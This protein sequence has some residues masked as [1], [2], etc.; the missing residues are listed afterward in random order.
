MKS[1]I[2]SIKLQKKIWFLQNHPFEENQEEEEENT[3]PL[4]PFHRKFTKIK[5]DGPEYSYNI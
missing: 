4:K 5:T 3:M 2:K 1:K